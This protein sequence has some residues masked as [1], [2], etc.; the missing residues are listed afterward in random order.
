MRHGPWRA[1]T[2]SALALSGCPAPEQPADAGRPDADADAAPRPDPELPA[3]RALFEASWDLDDYSRPVT[4]VYAARE[5]GHLF[6]GPGGLTA[7]GQALVAFLPTLG[8]HGL[9][10]RAIGLERLLADAAAYRP[11]AGLEARAA[12]ELRLAAAFA[13]ELDHMG[14]LL[15][16][17][18]ERTTD[19]AKNRW[20]ERTVR[21]VDAVQ[22][23]RAE[24]L[25]GILSALY[26]HTAAYAALQRGLAHYRA[27]ATG[28]PFP[29]PPWIGRRK[30]GWLEAGMKGPRVGRLVDRLAAE[31]LYPLVLRPTDTYDEHV[32]A[33]VLRFQRAH[34]L[35]EDGVVG[36]AMARWLPRPAADRVLRLRAALRRA[37]EA[38]SRQHA[39]FVWINVPEFSLAV[40][41]D[42]REVLR[43]GVVVGDETE[44]E[45]EET[46]E[47]SRPNA[48]PM[49]SS[50]I[51][52]VVINPLWQV[53]ERVKRE[54][55]D[56]ELIDD[57]NWYA[58]HGYELV[59]DPDGSERAIQLPGPSNSLGQVKVLFPN[60]ADVYLHD[61]PHRRLFSR[62]KRAYSHGCMRMERP[63][64]LARL[65]LERG[66]Q[67]DEEEMRRLLE[68]PE[69]DEEHPLG[70]YE[71]R[72]IKLE[73]T[74]PI[75]IEYRTAVHDG[76]GGVRLLEDLYELDRA[77]RERLAREDARLSE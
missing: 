23:A 3:R 58:A 31:G 56:L 69:I 63:V 66:G 76:A 47:R 46:G 32:T 74:L 18:Q 54:E 71:R 61:T 35:E 65:L 9:D 28:P 25:E 12:L 72:W 49:L 40:V 55:L 17:E 16:L 4:E 43:F 30:R 67:W 10:P 36:P 8:S 33:A 37:R 20:R 1:I 39:S 38:P 57:P 42:G 68:E 11:E 70:L 59:R 75:H 6:V 24:G 14:A 7:Q 60:P 48:T 52:H 27:L 51:T 21:Y 50:V 2:L 15:T 62:W 13:I 29:E 5:E 44:R 34:G 22:R 73:Q 45:D 19:W 26:P 64:E 77:Y 41:L 53:P